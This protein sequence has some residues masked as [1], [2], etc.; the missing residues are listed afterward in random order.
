MKEEI[1]KHNLKIIEKANK[2]VSQSQNSVRSGKSENQEMAIQSQD[3]INQNG[4]AD[5]SGPE[6]SQEGDRKSAKE[7]GTGGKMSKHSPSLA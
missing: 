5:S 6:T 2:R 7:A 4:M 1:E 3:E